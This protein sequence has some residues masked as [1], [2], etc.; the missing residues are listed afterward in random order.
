MVQPAGQLCSKWQ[1]IKARQ[2]VEHRQNAIFKRV[3]VEDI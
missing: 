3:F 2:F 1:P